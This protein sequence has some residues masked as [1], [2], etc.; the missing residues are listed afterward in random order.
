MLDCLCVWYGLLATG[1]SRQLLSAC[2]RG[3]SSWSDPPPLGER[4]AESKQS[5]DVAML[6]GGRRGRMGGAPGSQCDALP[7]LREQIEP[8]GALA[9]GPTAGAEVKLFP[10]CGKKVCRKG[11]QSQ[12]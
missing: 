3:A 7:G 2:F 12:K 1:S 6:C 10:L 9:T 8:A 5:E 4:S 11:L